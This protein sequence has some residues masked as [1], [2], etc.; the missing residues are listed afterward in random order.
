MCFEFYER[1][2][3]GYTWFQFV[4]PLLPKFEEADFDLLMPV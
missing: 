3:V 4:R 1:L 2:E